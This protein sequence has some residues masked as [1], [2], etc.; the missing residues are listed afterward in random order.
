MTV[1]NDN[2]SLE[3]IN[4]NS[5][6]TDFLYSNVVSLRQLTS[7]TSEFEK[8]MSGAI[9]DTLS[10]VIN[11]YGQ[12]PFYSSLITYNNFISQQNVFGNLIT[13]PNILDRV[14]KNV[15]ITPIEYAEFINENMYTPVSL[16][17]A[18]SVGPS[19]LLT[20][21]DSFYE[22]RFSKSSMGTFCA[23]APTIFGAI[24][25]FFSAIGNIATQIT[26]IINSIQNFSVASMLE[27]L[28]KSIIKVV[29]KQIEKIKNIISN[30]SVANIIDD[31]TTFVNSK[32]IE[33]ALM[34]KEE[35]MQFF[36]K[37]NIAAFMK[38][39]QG[40]ITYATNVFKN[41]TIEEIQF[42]IY[43]FCS[44]AS[45]VEDV[46]SAIKNPLD[47]FTSSYKNSYNILKSNSAMNT[48]RAVFSGAFRYD[49]GT[50]KSGY[51][52]GTNA[53]TTAGNPPPVSVADI[54]GV[55]S[56]ND[57][58][59]DFRI[60][61]AG[62]WVN[63][64]GEEGWI[65]VDPKARVYLMRLQTRM[66][67]QLIVNSGYRSPEY[68]AYLRSI[69][70]KAAINSQHMQGLACDI[71]FAGFNG[72]TTERFIEYALEEGFRGIGRYPNDG[73]VH[74]DIGPRREWKG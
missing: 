10:K 42:L 18:T 8:N 2:T 12:E 51:D 68:N 57:G 22:G 46:I 23:L 6:T 47:T 62:R 70:K 3:V 25:N 50:R 40:L 4:N 66:G 17:I 52:A 44:F 59:G 24:D 31:T 11:E 43:R 9:T 16:V 15:A 41:P 27:Q 63:M 35:A 20:L 65:K 69:G 37:E 67:K 29:E 13:Y 54:D 72:D 14:K 32:I 38:R 28:K 7:I 39:I 61:F 71:T 49:Q 53:A 48:S 45:Q 36:T 58:R 5:L 33:K 34:L 19:K 60:T 30:F 1:C 21:I 55:T 64:L 26:D 73:F 74:L 56:W